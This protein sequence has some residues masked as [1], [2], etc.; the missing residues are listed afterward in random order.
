MATIWYQK[1]VDPGLEP[2]GQQLDAMVNDNKAAEQLDP[3]AVQDAAVARDDDENRAREDLDPDTDNHLMGLAGLQPPEDMG[4]NDFHGN[5]VA[6]QQPLQPVPEQHQ[7]AALQPPDDLQEEADDANQG[8]QEALG[9]DESALGNQGQGQNENQIMP[10]EGPGPGLGQQMM[11]DQGQQIVGDQ[12]QGQMMMADQ[13]QIQFNQPLDADNIGQG[14][15]AAD[16]AA[17]QQALPA[18]G[19]V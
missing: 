3:G 16:I 18:P 4:Q 1:G 7:P 12:G 2:N 8:V 13:G 17:N 15:I 6:P 11:E 10:N 19:E 14:Q 5:E 9:P